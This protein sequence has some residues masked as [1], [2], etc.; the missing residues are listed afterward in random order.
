MSF[1][2]FLHFHLKYLIM[3]LFMYSNLFIWRFDLRL[4]VFNVCHWNVLGQE[5]IGSSRVYEALLYSFCVD[6]SLCDR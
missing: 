3:M 5:W 2:N 4:Q 6:D 1:Y